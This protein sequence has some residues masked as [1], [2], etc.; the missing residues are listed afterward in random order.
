MFNRK[1][2]E[3]LQLIVENQEQIIESLIEENEKLRL[4]IKEKCFIRNAKGQIQKI[5]TNKYKFH[6]AIV[7]IDE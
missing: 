6:E 1:K 7:G 3:R 5:K 4:F 2:V